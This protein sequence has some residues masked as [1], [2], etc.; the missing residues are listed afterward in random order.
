[1]G[2]RAYFSLIC[3]IKKHL[4]Q[5]KINLCFSLSIIFNKSRPTDI[6]TTDNQF[7]EPIHKRPNFLF[8]CFFLCEF[9]QFGH[10]IRF[11]LFIDSPSYIMLRPMVPLNL[12]FF[13]ISFDFSTFIYINFDFV[14]TCLGFIRQRAQFGQFLF[15]VSDKM[16][17]CDLCQSNRIISFQCSIEFSLKQI[18]EKAKYV[19]INKKKSLNKYSLRVF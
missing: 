4:F 19:H 3:R 17:Y 1:M 14:C 7:Q 10:E 15:G 12:L 8:F 16:R 18:V 6:V 13:F 2:G 9:R 11:G 5:L